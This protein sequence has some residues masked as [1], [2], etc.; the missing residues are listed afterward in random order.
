MSLIFIHTAYIIR[1]FLENN[2]TQ[3][4]YHGLFSLCAL[5]PGL[6]AFIR[7]SHLSVLYVRHGLDK[8]PD[9]DGPSLWTLVTD[10]NF[11]TEPNVVWESLEG[12]SFHCPILNQN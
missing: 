9:G 3:L 2:S 10:S 7:N 1:H 8:G 5:D 4:T 12:K 11:A 6:Y